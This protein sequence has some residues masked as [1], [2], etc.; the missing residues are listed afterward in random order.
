[1]YRVLVPVD[2]DVDR[3]LAQARYVT[4]LPAADEE[5]EAILLF[6]F[7]GDAEDLPSDLQ[8]FKTADR[9]QSVRRARDHLEDA[10]VEVQVR[11]DSGDT[12]DDILDDAEEY[13]VDAIVLGG[14]KRSPAGKAIFG[15][16]TQSVILNTDR[17]VVVTGDG[18]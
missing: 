3:A 8:Q 15:S 12:T 1:M 2:D 6:V 10:G 18:S 9:I 5:V 7:T 13:D 17:P 11:D 14:R 16:V 4:D